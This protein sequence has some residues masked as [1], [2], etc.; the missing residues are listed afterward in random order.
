MTA[1]WAIVALDDLAEVDALAKRV[2]ETFIFPA[3]SPE[4]QVAFS[5]NFSKSL[6]AHG[7]TPA[8]T[9]FGIHSPQQELIAYILIR[10]QA[11]IAHLFVAQG[12]QRRGLGQRLLS[13]AEHRAKQLGISRL[14]VNAAIN[15]IPFYQKHGFTCFDKEQ[16][17]EGVRF[18]PM[19]KAIATNGAPPASG[20]LFH[21][22]D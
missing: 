17:T 6:L 19:E 1:E 13:F 2:L 14:T 5:T 21:E 9:I 15:A 10:N 8:S 22:E 7:L 11:H 16:S 3:I 4:E 12:W 20:I 18:Q